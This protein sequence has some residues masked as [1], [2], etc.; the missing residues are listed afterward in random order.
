MAITTKFGRIGKEMQCLKG[1]GQNSNVW[2]DKERI[3]MFEWIRQE[4]TCLK[5]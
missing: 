4:F 2:K 1:E 5:G 3:T